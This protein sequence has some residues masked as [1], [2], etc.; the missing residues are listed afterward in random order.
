M[1]IRQLF[2][3]PIRIYKKTLSPLLG[4]H[5]R[6]YPSC[7]DYTYQAIET[8]GVRRG[9]RLGL[10]RLLKCHPFHEGGYDPIPKGRFGKAPEAPPGGEWGL[11]PV[12][13]IEKR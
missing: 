8:H 12:P 5:C 1:I 13:E 10:R 7:A 3:F 9:L 2:L 11:D 4:N 6:F